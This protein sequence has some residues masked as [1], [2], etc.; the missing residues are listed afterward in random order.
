[1]SCGEPRSWRPNTYSFDMRLTL[2]AFFGASLNSAIGNHYGR[3]PVITLASLLAFLGAAL[4]AGS[5][6]LPMIMIARFIK[7]VLYFAWTDN[8]LTTSQWAR[9]RTP[10]ECRPYTDWRDYKAP[11]PRHDYGN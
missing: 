5:I 11:T 3:R 8:N 2:G 10:H 6:N 4:Q 9:R 7:L 1:M